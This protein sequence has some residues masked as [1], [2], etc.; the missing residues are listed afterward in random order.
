MS[1]TKN[2]ELLPLLGT[3]LNNITYRIKK[4]RYSILGH[5]KY[6]NE[7]TNMCQ[8]NPRIAK[9]YNKSIQDTKG[10]IY[11]LQNWIND[12]LQL[13]IQICYIMSK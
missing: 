1:N 2:A 7:V 13:N 5:E 8:G 10:S 4:K 6:F 3:L 12:T 11:L 9:K